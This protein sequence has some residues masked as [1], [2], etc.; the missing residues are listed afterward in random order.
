[1]SNVSRESFVETDW[2]EIFQWKFSPRN[3]RN[4]HGSGGGSPTSAVMLWTLALLLTAGV[5]DA[6]STAS[7]RWVRPRAGELA[8]AKAY[9]DHMVLAA[10]PSKSSVWGYGEPGTKVTVSA[11]AAADGREVAA[12]EAVVAE[13]GTWKVLLA[14]VTTSSMSHKIIASST[15]TSQQSAILRDVLFGSVWVCGGQVLAL[16]LRLHFT[17]WLTTRGCNAIAVKYGIHYRRVPRVS[18][19]PGCGDE[20]DGGDSR[21]GRLST[22][23]CDDSWAAV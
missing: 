20:R 19:G 5:V 10:A 1:M 13:D 12:A 2:V 23:P 16:V 4:A 3:M 15:G 6:A 18:R 21:G 17:Q 9:G 14:P 7:P 8:F 22:G 11:L